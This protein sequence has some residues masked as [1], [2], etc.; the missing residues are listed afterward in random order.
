MKGHRKTDC[1]RSGRMW[2]EEVKPL[3][4]LRFGPPLF[5][6]EM[7]KKNLLLGTKCHY[8]NGLP[9]YKNEAIAWE[10]KAA[11]GELRWGCI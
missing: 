2:S 10:H 8:S 4:E 5:V 7:F 6:K 1:N 11:L 9:E 3:R